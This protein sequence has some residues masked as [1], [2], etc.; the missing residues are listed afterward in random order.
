MAKIMDI[1]SKGSVLLALGLAACSDDAPLAPD[2][3]ADSDID[4]AVEPAT[5]AAGSFAWTTKF[6]DGSI[7]GPAVAGVHACVITHPSIPCTDT[8][9]DG[10]WTFCA[11]AVSEIAIAYEKS[12]YMPAIRPF[13]TGT[14][15]PPHARA[16]NLVLRVPDCEMWSSGGAACPP[17]TSDAGGLLWVGARENDFD[18]DEFPG[19]L[20]DVSIAL[21]PVAMI[22][23]FY[24]VTT[25]DPTLVATDPANGNALAAD[26]TEGDQQL[27]TITRP[28]QVCHAYAYHAWSGTAAGTI[29]VPIRRGYRTFAAVTCEAP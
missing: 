1:R 18:A 21:D 22:G 3:G 12:G 5:C 13:V 29:R 16:R 14:A 25:A 15:Q 24:G 4:A 11:P 6:R 28:D 26:V 8:A 9:I 10:T 7:T 20:G 2:A 17:S 27:V 19:P 23:P